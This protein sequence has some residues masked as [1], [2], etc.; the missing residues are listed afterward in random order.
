MVH[1]ID[2]RPPGV[3]FAGRR[4]RRSRREDASVYF[5]ASNGIQLLN[6]G[7]ECAT[8]GTQTKA[9]A[10]PNSRNVMEISNNHISESRV[11]ALSPCDDVKISLTDASV[12]TMDNDSETGTSPAR[13]LTQSEYIEEQQRL[14]ENLLDQLLKKDIVIDQLRQQTSSSESRLPIEE[15]EEL[16]KS[17][18]KEVQA[19]EE[20]F[21]NY[22]LYHVQKLQ[23]AMC[24]VDKWKN[25]AKDLSVQL[26]SHRKLL[27]S[28]CDESKNNL[29]PTVTPGDSSERG[30]HSPA[31]KKRTVY[32]GRFLFENPSPG[33]PPY[34]T[35][36]AQSKP[37]P[38]PT[39]DD[40]ALRAVLEVSSRKRKK[41]RNEPTSFTSSLVIPNRVLT[42]AGQPLPKLTQRHGNPQI[43][44]CTMVIHSPVP[45]DDYD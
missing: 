18:T 17:Y 33:K 13:A 7:T 21:K 3:G 10:T 40:R 26:D 8:A 24:E 22:R 9:N 34:P 43:P 5:A 23:E 19:L 42:F 36:L 1:A 45:C 35:P 32:N 11:V 2:N 44:H 29:H 31:V 4:R 14:I 20:E 6:D 39:P 38:M 41:P 16:L 25:E 37:L 30:V 12:Q 28:S 27:A 15:R